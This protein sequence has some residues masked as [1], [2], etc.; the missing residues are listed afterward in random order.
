MRRNILI[1]SLSLLTLTLIYFF[2]FQKED[3]QQVNEVLYTVEQAAFPITV[4]ATGELDSKK[5]VK[6]RGPQGMRSAR[7]FETTISDLV[8]EGTILKEGDYVGKLD[9]TEL[10]NRMGNIQVEIDQIKTQL[11]QA[12]IDTAINMRDMRDQ[13]VNT[14]FSLKEKRLSVDLNRYEA[15][16]VI[17]QTQLE[18]EKAE[19]YY[20][21]LLEQYTLKQQQA[22]AQIEEIM[23]QLRKNEM[24][25]SQLLDL[26]D[27]FTIPAPSDGM[28][29]YSRDWNG[30]KEPGS[31]VT[32]WDPVVAEL[33]DLTDMISKLY[34]N[35][36]DISKVTKGQP[37]DI[38]IDAFPDLAYTG[39][40]IQVAN[41]GE[42]V[43]GYDTK[44]FEVI[45]QVNE[46]DSIMR[47]AMTTSNEI[48]TSLYDD[49][50]SVPLEAMQ[51][52]TLSYVYVK[53][54]N[55]IIAREII[56][57]PANNNAIMVKHGLEV[58]DQVLLT[59]PDP[60]KEY[61]VEPIHP[62][63][64]TKIEAE[65]AADLA[66]RKAEAQKRAASIKEMEIRT[67]DNGGGGGIIIIN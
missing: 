36:V 44:V 31:R 10:A 30:K 24:E 26:S 27:K 2:F 54:G 62:D 37:V 14:Q 67:S 4:V 63:I 39:T 6:I 18:L 41:I 19:R 45:V 66:K 59:L 60:N 3:T 40:V 64:K 53:K 23:T 33:P 58:G 1:T 21:Q 35:E 56:T 34:V 29:I 11:E 61:P 22:D 32:A 50:I 38:K 48:L 43:R 15:K 52:D 7:I 8:P 42:Q 13:I 65:L 25:M 49:V 28:L 47:P 12:K 20:Q 16:S 51:A 55:Q 57:G 9:Q 46:T 5:S 17:R